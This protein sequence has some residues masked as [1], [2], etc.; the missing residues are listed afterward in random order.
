MEKLNLTRAGAERTVSREIS[1]YYS[2]N[3]KRGRI[4]PVKMID[5]VRFFKG[6]KTAM[7]GNKGGY[8]GMT[9]R[10]TL[11]ALIGDGH[12]TSKQFSKLLDKEFGSESRSKYDQAINRNIVKREKFFKF[13][14]WRMSDSPQVHSVAGIRCLPI[15]DKE[16]H[17]FE[18][19]RG[20]FDGVIHKAKGEKFDSAKS[21]LYPRVLE[22]NER[23]L[24]DW[25]FAKS[26]VDGARRAGI[27]IC[28]RSVHPPLWYDIQSW[29]EKLCGTKA[30]ERAQRATEPVT[31]PEPEP[32][33]YKALLAKLAL[34]LKKLNGPFTLYQFLDRFRSHLPKSIGPCEVEACLRELG[35]IQETST[36]Q[37]NKPIA[38]PVDA[39]QPLVEAATPAESQTQSD[40]RTVTPFAPVA[41]DFQAMVAELGLEFELEDFLAIYARRTGRQTTKANA[42]SI[43]KHLGYLPQDAVEPAGVRTPDQP[44][45]AQ[46]TEPPIPARQPQSPQWKKPGIKAVPLAVLRE[47]PED[48]DWACDDGVET[49]DD[50]WCLR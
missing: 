42:L 20:Q 17:W 24:D 16:C 26:E 14:F 36:A 10:E 1:T 47:M 50:E 43:L 18:L 11:R 21:K 33:G 15:E 46:E 13:T 3:G 8:Q 39:S 40:R 38:E 12:L 48:E 5:G 30:T 34:S 29:Q 9:L 25:R 27:L 44:S 7:P 6:R 31:E 4:V 22:L 19:Y 49:Y 41:I 45:A 32:I 23:P 35:Y 2:S 37:E 28:D